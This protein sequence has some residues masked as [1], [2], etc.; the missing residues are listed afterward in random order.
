MTSVIKLAYYNGFYCLNKNQ[1]ITQMGHLLI[2]DPQPDRI[3]PLITTGRSLQFVE[4]LKFNLMVGAT[5][6]F[7]TI[8][9]EFTHM[10]N[11]LRE[12]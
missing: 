9:V 6:D 7:A 10:G 8:V 12:C 5:T 11:S 3:T 2:I 4:E 1:K